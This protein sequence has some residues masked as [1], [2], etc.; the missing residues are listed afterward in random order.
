MYNTKFPS[1]RVAT[2]A[3]DSPLKY[4]GNLAYAFAK[5]G[6]VLLAERL[7]CAGD[8]GAPVVVS[9]HP[10]WV[11]TPAVAVAYGEQKKWLEPMRNGWEGAEGICYLLSCAK[12]ELVGGAFYLDREPQRKHVAGWF[13]G[14]GTSTKNTPE[15][16]DQM[17]VKLKE[18]AGL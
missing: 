4:D 15:E 17:M 7:S 12:N 6:Q 14:E 16:V 1:W 5:R 9:A 11:D 13:M 3:P 8:S 18:A 10:G 2:S